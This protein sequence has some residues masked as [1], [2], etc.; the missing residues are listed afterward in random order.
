MVLTASPESPPS[1]P[2]ELL[3]EE[4][5]KRQRRRRWLIAGAVIALIAS[6]LAFRWVDGGSGS[7]SSGPAANDANGKAASATRSYSEC[8]G[9]D[10]PKVG[11][12]D[13]LPPKGYT[14]EANVRTVAVRSRSLLDS[15]FPGITDVR[16][17]PRNGQVWSYDTT[18]QVVVE[19]MR[20]FE[21]EV[22]LQAPAYC[23]GNPWSWGGVPLRFVSPT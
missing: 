15:Q 6:A 20:D 23:P 18:G 16:V 22:R 13:A 5:R 4:A 1:E 7:N 8:P 9:T 21:I 17:I 3:I 11:R 19:Q 2:A 14:D 10:N 12:G